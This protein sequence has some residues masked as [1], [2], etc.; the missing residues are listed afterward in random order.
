MSLAL[1]SHLCLCLCLCRCPPSAA[2]VCRLAAE[3]HLPFGD[4]LHAQLVLAHTATVDAAAG[5]RRRAVMKAAIRHF[6]AGSPS[7]RRI[8]ANLGESRRISANR[9]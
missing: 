2:Q 5:S 1:L 3:H 8:S 6:E 9:G 7:S 4:R